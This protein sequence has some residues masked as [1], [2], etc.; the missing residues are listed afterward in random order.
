[1]RAAQGLQ[2]AAAMRHADRHPGPHA[3][4]Q[5]RRVQAVTRTASKPAGLEQPGQ[6]LGGS[7]KSSNSKSSTWG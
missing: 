2:P 6:L 7:S 3:A 5:F 1:M 4:Q